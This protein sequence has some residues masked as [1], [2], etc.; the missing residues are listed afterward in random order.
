MRSLAKVG[1]IA[2]AIFALQEVGA[3]VQAQVRGRCVRYCAP[4]PSRHREPQPIQLD[5][6]TTFYVPRVHEAVDFIVLDGGRSRPMIDN[7]NLPIRPGAE[8]VTGPNGSARFELADGTE[9]RLG[10][11]TKITLVEYG[12][13]RIEP[14][15]TKLDVDLVQGWMRWIDKGRSSISQS[16]DRKVNQFKYRFQVRAC[17][18]AC[19]SAPRG[20]DFEVSQSESGAGF[21]RVHDGEV[22]FTYKVRARPVPRGYVAEVDHPGYAYVQP[23]Q[24]FRWDDNDTWRE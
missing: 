1:A 11:N 16:L 21:L 18:N 7:L 17:R 19:A 22:L 20:T 2:M 23:G 4:P 24:T 5:P 8:L 15:K 12:P 9:V 10:A 6:A 13:D 14:A 3:V